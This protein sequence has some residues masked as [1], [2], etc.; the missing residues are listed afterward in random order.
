M[1]QSKSSIETF[2]STENFK[3]AQLSPSILLGKNGKHVAFLFLCQVH[4]SNFAKIGAKIVG[5]L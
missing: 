1:D 4:G 2:F 3:G 5:N